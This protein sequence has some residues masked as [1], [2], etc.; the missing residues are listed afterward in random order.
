MDSSRLQVQAKTAGNCHPSK[1]TKAA[2]RTHFARLAATRNARATRAVSISK[3]IGGLSDKRGRARA[4]SPE[5]WSLQA[6]PQLA[7]REPFTPYKHT[8]M[9][10]H[11]V[12]RK[13]KCIID[14]IPRCQSDRNPSANNLIQVQTDKRPINK[15]QAMPLGLKRIR[16]EFH[17]ARISRRRGM[18][19]APREG[20]SS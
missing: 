11:F 16:V 13:P 14:T 10:A 12:C 7:T 18:P 2:L 20:V 17:K 19:H 5:R 8:S 9:A 3:Q 6:L 1:C 15:M 4:K